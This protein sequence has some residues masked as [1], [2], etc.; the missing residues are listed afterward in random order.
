MGL[1]LLPMILIAQQPDSTERDSI[2]QTTIL[3]LPNPLLVHR[4][5]PP[6]IYKKWWKEVEKCSHLYV[7][8]IQRQ[9]VQWYSINAD[10][11]VFKDDS[12][13]MIDSGH[14]FLAYTLSEIDVIFIADRG[15]TGHGIDNEDTVKHEMIHYLMYHNGLQPGHPKEIYDRCHILIEKPSI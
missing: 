4:V 13:E 7:P 14:M 5:D 12:T 11:F 1:L 6:L 9:K 3:V 10:G 8:Y 2:R 15:G